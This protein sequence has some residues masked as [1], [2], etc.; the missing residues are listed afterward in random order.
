MP[1]FDHTG[2]YGESSQTGKKQGLC[3][4]TAQQ[5]QLAYRFRQHNKGCKSKQSNTK[6][7][8]D[9]LHNEIVGIKR[10]RKKRHNH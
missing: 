2:P 8:F 6:Q 1:Q 7:E 9:F 3:S 4:G 10:C 5:G